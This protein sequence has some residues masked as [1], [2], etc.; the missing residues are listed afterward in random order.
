MTTHLGSLEKHA[1]EAQELS[2]PNRKVQP[3]VLHSCIKCA[4]KLC[5][6]G[7]QVRFLESAPEGS[8]VCFAKRVKVAP[9]RACV[10]REKE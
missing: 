2:L 5:H 10:R 4:W 1:S 3:L 9:H 7:L 8:V 6:N